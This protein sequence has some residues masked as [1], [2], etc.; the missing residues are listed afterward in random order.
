M[1]NCIVVAMCLVAGALSATPTVA[2]ST[3]YMENG[4]SPVFGKN[5]D[6]SVDT[7]LIMVNKRGVVKTAMPAEHPAQWVSKYG[8]VTFNQYGRELPAGGMNE[9]GLVVELMWL[10]NAEYPALDDRAAVGNVQWIQY[11]LDNSRTVAE[12]IATDATLRIS[13]LTTSKI[14]YLVGDSDGNSAAIE[15]VAGKMVVHTGDDMPAKALTNDTYD[16]SMNYLKDFDG[17]GGATEIKRSQSSL[18]RF[19]CAADMVRTAEAADV[20]ATVDYGFGILSA[21]AQ[22]EYTLWSIVYDI[23]GR[24]VYFRTARAPGRRYIDLSDFDFSCENPVMVLDI[25]ADLRGNVASSFVEYSYDANRR[26][27]RSTFRQTPFL[28]KTPDSALEWLARY[29]DNAIC[30]PATGSAGS[31]N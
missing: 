27:I 26:L 18:D 25:N 6:W 11:Q 23:A 2:C 15:F 24:R 21:V 16:R 12:V 28:S 22:G 19:A 3:F 20:A 17:F 31:A 10:E 5:Y 1:K 30:E 8:S 9:V 13:R 29:P 4:G 7:G 14:H